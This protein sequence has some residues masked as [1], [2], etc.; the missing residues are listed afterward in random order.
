MAL[1]HLNFYRY[2]NRLPVIFSRFARA[3]LVSLGLTFSF[4][5]QAVGG[6]LDFNVYPY[7]NDVDNDSA[8]TLNAATKLPGRFS[9][10]SLTNLYNQRDNGFLDDSITYYTEQNFRWQVAED[11]PLDLTLQMNFRTGKDNNRHRLGV[12][13]RLNNTS[14]FKDFFDSINLRYAVNLHAIQF[15]HEDGHVW[16]IEHAFLMKFPSISERLYLS[17]FIDHTF[18]QQ[19]PGH[20]P[21]NPIV[22][23][24]QLGL[25]LVDKLFFVSE[26]RI[27]QYRRNDVNNLAV[28][29]QYKITW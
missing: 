20:L 11:S 3:F 25:L 17:G 27:N 7:L 29:L 8:F 1:I 6:F 24:F 9:Y 12:R 18:N 5:F 28:G 10:F 4:A 21:T 14:W 23:E 2:F 15:D 22:A 13:W 26:Y 16:Q 19:R